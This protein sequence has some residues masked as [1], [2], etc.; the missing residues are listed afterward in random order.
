M[1]L[2]GFDV[3]WTRF[4][5][6]I[7]HPYPTV[8]DTRYFNF[9]HSATL[10][11]FVSF[12]LPGFAVMA[13]EK[14][15]LEIL[16]YQP[17]KHI[18]GNYNK[19]PAISPPG[20]GPGGRPPSIL[21]GGTVSGG[22]DSG[23]GGRGGY[24]R[25]GENR[26]NSIGGG[27]G[28]GE[29]VDT[30][31]NSDLR[32]ISQYDQ[33]KSYK[34][35]GHFSPAGAA[36]KAEG[37][38][39]QVHPVALCNNDDYMGYPERWVG[40]M[41]LEGPQMTDCMMSMYEKAERAIDK[42]ASAIVFD[43]TENPEAARQLRRSSQTL[44][45]RPVVIIRGREAAKLME[46]VNTSKGRRAR[47]RI[48]FTAEE[49]IP[50][51][52]SPTT[53]KAI[54]VTI[55]I[56]FCVVCLSIVL[57]WK[58]RRER[59][60]SVSELA[61]RAVSKLETRKYTSN[62]LKSQRPYTPTSDLY[63]QSSGIDA[64]AICLEDYKNGQELRV[65]PCQHEFH[66][67]CVDPWLVTNR[68]CPL[69]LHNIMAFHS[70]SSS[71]GA[72]S[73]HSSPNSQ[74]QSPRGAIPSTSNALTST[75]MNQGVGG[76]D[77]LGVG[78]SGGGGSNNNHLHQYHH[79][80]YYHHPHQH[81]SG[82]QSHNNRNS[83][84]IK[85]TSCDTDYFQTL[86]VQGSSRSGTVTNFLYTCPSCE[87]K[88]TNAVGGSSM[89][90]SNSSMA[91]ASIAAKGFHT[92]H[93]S[94]ANTPPHSKLLHSLQTRASGLDYAH[95]L[96]RALY[97]AKSYGRQVN[98][99]AMTTSTAST[100]TAATSTSTGMATSPVASN[101]GLVHMFPTPATAAASSHNSDNACSSPMFLGRTRFYPS[102]RLNSWESDPEF[103]S[104]KNNISTV[105]TCG[106]CS[107]DQNPSIESLQ[108]N[109][110][111]RMSDS[112]FIDSNQST[113][114]STDMKD[115]SDVS[116]YDSN[117]YRSETPESAKIDC[118]NRTSLPSH[119]NSYLS[120]P[121]SGSKKMQ[122]YNHH[123]NNN[124]NNNNNNK[125]HNHP[126][127][128]IKPHPKQQQPQQN[129][130][131]DSYYTSRHKAVE[132]CLDYSSSSDTSAGSYVDRKGGRGL[133]R[134]ICNLSQ[135]S[136]EHSLS[137][138][139]AMSGSDE[140]FSSETS[141]ILAKRS[142][143]LSGS[144]TTTSTS[145]TTSTPAPPP[146]DLPI[147]KDDSS[148]SSS[149]NATSNT[150]IRSFNETRSFTQNCLQNKPS[151]HFPSPSHN[152]HRHSRSISS[153]RHAAA[154][155]NRH[156]VPSLRAKLKPNGLPGSTT[157]ASGTTAAPLV[158]I[159][160]G[161]RRGEEIWEHYRL[162]KGR[163]ETG[164]GL[165]NSG[166][167]HCPLPLDRTT[168]QK[169][170]NNISSPPSPAPATNPLS[171]SS[172]LNNRIPTLSEEEEEE[173]DDDEVE[174]NSDGSVPPPA[175]S[176]PL[177]ATPRLLT[178]ER[179]SSV[180]LSSSH[181]SAAS[182][183]RLSSSQHGLMCPRCIKH[184]H[185]LTASNPRRSMVLFTEPQGTVMTLPLE[186]KERYD[187]SNAV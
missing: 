28:D 45:E 175:P 31:L 120:N 107:S 143:V 141:H 150:V 137:Q 178:L 37:P 78:A 90:P 135:A 133:K 112:T 75:T 102:K 97:L 145:A 58:F 85:T 184:N 63:S 49:R 117:V 48:W 36:M 136:S 119:R 108:C 32:G 29:A 157:V 16:L 9:Q 162:S 59:Q 121:I 43:I 7:R 64:C 122:P 111:R 183:G 91:G 105:A 131:R 88:R 74:P 94:S 72:M 30:F 93:S 22:G 118:S 173:E 55:F 149:P 104:S 142:P 95:A 158:G 100:T 21:S 160:S 176:V 86:A 24:G 26:R 116:S 70:S 147:R 182:H 15:I 96:Q 66:R 2:C 14:A 5:K 172:V 39:I 171:P 3:L 163:G 181:H 144:S 41:K 164:L 156:S 51:G 73:Q 13:K 139:S 11:L 138:L 166:D 62:K 109:C 50:E 6:M 185:S 65:L 76:S 134:S 38:I 12:L 27:G 61:K 129:R 115:P 20:P 151:K 128:H 101:S 99:T 33:Y 153:R 187:P 17:S 103:A 167:Q 8:L 34:L 125:S 123:H 98:S 106:S 154:M 168:P 84:A 146:T 140:S 71:S 18:S 23:T 19:P 80:H 46:I 174:E 52:V 180:C 87:D 159:L 82:L 89:I 1:A 77:N 179:L 127:H 165:G 155:R 83:T 177:P 148:S 169:T 56:I 114:G 40:V 57:K 161:L 53:Y 54:V 110:C 124:K 152:R 69:C 60:S 68:T 4:H 35:S 170:P 81:K 44:L 130:K 47:V 186:E 132:Y 67:N 42:G 92:N 113:Y 10:L 79:R 126:H 25:H